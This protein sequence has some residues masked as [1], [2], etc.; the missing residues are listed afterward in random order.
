M[1]KGLFSLIIS[2]LV[3]VFCITLSISYAWYANNNQVNVSTIDIS[4]IKYEAQ[5]DFYKYENDNWVK[6]DENENALKFSLLIPSQYKIFRIDIK[7][8]GDTSF[9]YHLLIDKYENSNVLNDDEQISDYMYM[10]IKNIQSMYEFDNTSSDLY[11]NNYNPLDKTIPFS[12]NG[13][14]N[15]NKM[16]INGTL[17]EK[18]TTHLIFKVYFSAYASVKQQNQGFEIKKIRIVG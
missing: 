5:V 10:N 18:E 6:V 9:D 11:D 7:N 14:S 13:Q 12:I 1:K 2:I 15:I 3:F 17:K 4:A 8:I 16:K